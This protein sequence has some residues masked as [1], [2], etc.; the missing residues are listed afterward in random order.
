MHQLRRNLKSYLI[1][2]NQILSCLFYTHLH[3]NTIQPVDY[4]MKDF[5]NLI[6]HYADHWKD[7]VESLACFGPKSHKR[8]VINRLINSYILKI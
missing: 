3:K 7:W 6:R 2:S 4:M 1:L 8:H 5:M